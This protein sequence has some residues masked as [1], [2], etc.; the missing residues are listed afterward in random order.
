MTRKRSSKKRGNSK[1]F[2]KRMSY[3]RRRSGK[4]N[5]RIPRKT[6]KKTY[7]NI[8]DHSDL[9][10]D[11]NPKGTVKGLKFKNKQ[12]AKKSVKKLRSLYKSKK[13]TFS[14]MR[15]IGVTFEQ[16]AKYHIHKNKDIKE[17]EKVW[18]NFNRSFKKR[19]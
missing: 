5:P 9:F 8:R 2:Y 12:E 16:R 15:Q 3:Y 10:T 13:I 17:G 1:K 14:H 7:K 18:K 11:E 6:K 4:S 19:S